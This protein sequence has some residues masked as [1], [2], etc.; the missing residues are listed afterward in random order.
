MRS[1]LIIIMSALIGA[2][3]SSQQT[4]DVS[5]IDAASIQ[6]GMGVDLVFDLVDKVYTFAD[7]DTEGLTELGYVSP[8]IV[9]LVRTSQIKISASSRDSTNS[10]S[11]VANHSHKRRAAGRS[12]NIFAPYRGVFYLIALSVVVFIVWRKVRR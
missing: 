10:V 12:Y 9:P 2:C 6:R 5:R 3:R 1:I 7:P 4:V 8:H 11:K